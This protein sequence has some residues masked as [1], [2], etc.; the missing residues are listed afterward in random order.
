M[1]LNIAEGHFAYVIWIVAILD[2][3]KFK[4]VS[5]VCNRHRILETNFFFLQP[6]FPGKGRTA[7]IGAYTRYFIVHS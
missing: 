4:A 3:E 2:I 5:L 7:G 1:S 6:V